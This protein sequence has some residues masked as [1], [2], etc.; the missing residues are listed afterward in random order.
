[1]NEG[2]KDGR[3][4]KRRDAN[5]KVG[6]ENGIEKVNSG[7]TEEIAIEDLAARNMEGC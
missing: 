4:G 2:R 3:G 5:E 7:K 1:M 6:S